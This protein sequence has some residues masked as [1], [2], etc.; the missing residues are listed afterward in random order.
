MEVELNREDEYPEYAIQNEI[1]KL[2]SQLY[3]K[4][5]VETENYYEVTTAKDMGDMFQECAEA[6]GEDVELKWLLTY[7]DMVNLTVLLNIRGVL[8]AWVK[9]HRQILERGD[10]A[11]LNPTGREVTEDVFLITSHQESLEYYMIQ[12]VKVLSIINA[13][14]EENPE[15]DG[16]KEMWEGVHRTLSPNITRLLE[17]ISPKITKGVN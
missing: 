9:T 15:E 16:L 8:R 1:G 7:P 4:M 10:L 2:V 6:L 14:I 11:M 5:F 3:N 17:T 12:L 13:N